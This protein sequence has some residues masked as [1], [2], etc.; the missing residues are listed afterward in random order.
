MRHYYR[1]MAVVTG[2]FV[3]LLAAANIYMQRMELQEESRMH[4]V[5]ANRIRQEIYHYEACNQT[6]PKNLGELEEYAG[7]GE[8]TGIAA[9]E[10]LP[11]QQADTEGLQLFFNNDGVEY[12]VVFTEM[13]YYKILFETRV[14]DKSAFIW[15]VNV[16][17]VIFWLTA[18]G[19]MWYIRSR[20]MKPFENISALPYE[21]AKGNLVVP[22]KAQR[23]GYL[24]EFIWGMDMLREQLETQKVRELELHKEKKLLVLSLS[25]DIKTPLS[26][27]KLYA[28]ALGRNLYK[29]TQRQKEVAQLMSGKVDEMESYIADIVRSSRE[30]FMEFDVHVKELYIKEILEY[31]REYYEDKMSLNQICFEIGTYTDCLVMADGE[32]LVE[33]IQNVIENAFKYGDGR[34]ISVRIEQGTE[35]FRIYVENTGCTMEKKELAHIYDSFFRGTN[36]GRQAGSGL[37]LY[38]CRELMLRMDGEI[39]ARIC[40]KDGERL[41]EMCIAVRMAG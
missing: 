13:A 14:T 37:G 23:S 6:V 40:E 12:T 25:H 4:I 7:T 20:I 35:E 17:G 2:I 27:L 30:D 9:L 34:Y 28:Q 32:R 19:V 24:K 16:A 5:S 10:I 36:V 1:I 26:A 3:I 21:L 18:L 29:S 33:V 41:M 8:Y 39:T 38:I 11:R 22:L 15:I 31:I